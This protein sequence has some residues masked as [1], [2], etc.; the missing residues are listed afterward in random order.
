M[1]DRESLLNDKEFLRSFMDGSDLQQFFRELQVGAVSQMLEGKLDDH[2]GYSKHARSDEKNSRNG[3][4]TKKVR[5]DQGDIEIQ[6]PRD[7][8]GSFN[9]I[10]VPKRKNIIDG[11]ENVIVSLYAK[12]M[13][14]M[15][16]EDMLR[17]VLWFS[18]LRIDNFA[19]YRPR[20]PRCS[21]LAKSSIRQRLSNSLDGWHCL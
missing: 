14:V 15:D 7:R 10:L 21:S 8:E 11:V 17:Y 12:G 6:V 4:T 16:I 13:S 18:S 20:S 9:P 1:I 5:G 3:H 19:H 2:L